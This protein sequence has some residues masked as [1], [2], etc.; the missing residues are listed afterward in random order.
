ME[1]LTF[2][3]IRELTPGHRWR[4]LFDATWAG[5]FMDRM[6]LTAA[7]CAAFADALAL[8]L[9]EADLLAPPAGSR[10]R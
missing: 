10:A 1:P 5:Y 6:H 9:A 2:Y 4:Q 3:G 7:G 8:L